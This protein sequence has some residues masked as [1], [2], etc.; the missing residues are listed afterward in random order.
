MAEWDAFRIDGGGNGS[1][2]LKTV[3]HIVHVPIG[4]R[5]IED[6]KI[7]AGLVYD[8]SRLNKSRISVAWVSANSW[9]FGSIYGTVEFQFDWD[10]LVTNQYIYWIE[11]MD[12]RPKAYRFLLSKRNFQ[13]IGPIKRYDPVND[14]GPLRFSDG[15][16]YWNAA[17]TSEF[18]IEDDLSL[19]R[20]IGIEFVLH[21]KDWCRPYGPSC[22]DRLGQPTVSYTGGR[23]LSFVLGSG[24]HVIDRHLKPPDNNSFMRLNVADG[25]LERALSEEINFTNV[26]RSDGNCQT[27]VRGALALYGLDQ[28]DEARALVALMPSKDKFTNALKAIIRQHFGDAGWEPREIFPF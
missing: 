3:R 26:V 6:G 17:Y 11:A 1:A 14:T 24:L 18:M 21:N 5:I 28:A 15:K 12:Y 10:D 22:D 4:H 19:E 27:I 8:E 9:V 7:K 20:C 23:V 16:F 2:E 13:S 25:G